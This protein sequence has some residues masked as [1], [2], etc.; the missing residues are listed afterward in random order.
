MPYLERHKL[1]AP[2]GRCHPD[3]KDRPIPQRAQPI[4]L[5]RGQHVAQRRGVRRRLAALR[6]AMLGADPGQHL[7]EPAR[8]RQ[9]GRGRIARGTMLMPD[10]RDAAIDRRRIDPGGRLV[11]REYRHDIRRCRQGCQAMRIAPSCEDRPIRLIRSPRRGRSSRLG[12]SRRPLDLGIEDRRQRRL[13]R[14]RY[15]EHLP[16]VTVG[17]DNRIGNEPLARHH[18]AMT[19]SI[20]T[21]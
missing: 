18:P 13:E 11:A 19:G 2:Q 14:D 12:I 15:S 10:R 17:Q 20:R 16:V 9:S 21:H 3:R 6:P 8:G 7:G 1:R 4:P 5:D